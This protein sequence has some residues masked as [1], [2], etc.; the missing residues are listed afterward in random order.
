[1]SQS[2][3]NPPHRRQR[4]REIDAFDPL[5]LD[6]LQKVI[7]ERLEGVQPEQFPPDDFLGAGVYALYYV[8]DFD[9]YAPLRESQCRVPIY[10]GKAE[11]GNSSYGDPADKGGL[12]LIKRIEKH[13][14]SVAEATETLDVRDFRVRYLP[15]DDAWIVLAERALLRSYRPVIWNTVMPGFGSNV[16][17]SDRQNARS[18]WD[19]V[20]PGRP[21]AGR[22]CNR[23]FTLAEMH[24]RV[25]LAIAAS[26]AIDE[27]EQDDAIATLE[28]YRKRPI[29][30]PKLGRE[31]GPRVVVQDIDRFTAEMD[32]LGLE[33][34][35]YRVVSDEN[36]ASNDPEM[37][38]ERSTSPSALDALPG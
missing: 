23:R 24:E 20:H 33:I 19:T 9:L 29:W 30:R 28:D 31:S 14:K 34:P 36:F 15:I 12:Q 11:A 21:R 32:R 7:R 2:Q 10:V 8:G 37:L 3:A 25:R 16:P 13:A 18:I 22:L 26:V 35:E 4:A 27:D 6:S 1:M 38:A 5:S 17:G